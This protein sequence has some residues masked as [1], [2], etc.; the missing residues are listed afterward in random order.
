[1]KVVCIENPSVDGDTQILKGIEVGK[2]YEVT[3]VIF[4]LD[5]TLINWDNN[6]FYFFLYL[7]YEKD[8][9]R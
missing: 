7:H 4:S 6:Y 8:T 9:L 3:L 5:N 1:M 2:V